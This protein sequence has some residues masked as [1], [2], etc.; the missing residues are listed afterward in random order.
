MEQVKYNGVI[1]DTELHA[2]WAVFFSALNIKWEYRMR[3]Y[4][5][6]ELGEYTPEFNIRL[7]GDDY[8]DADNLK[9]VVSVQGVPCE[10]QEKA[11]FF[12]EHSYSF[13]YGGCRFFREL[14]QISERSYV[15]NEE[16]QCEIPS[17][18]DSYIYAQMLNVSV[19]EYNRAIRTAQRKRLRVYKEKREGYVYRFIDRSGNVIYVGRTNDML[20]RM[21]QHFSSNG[22]L[23]KECYARTMRVEYIEVD[24]KNDMKIKELYYIG[25]LM[26]EYNRA[27]KVA[28][29][30][31]ID[32][33]VDKW[34]LYTVVKGSKIA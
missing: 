11:T 18:D 3:S 14:K 13:G 4:D 15:W 12:E 7:N 31:S 23:P 33:T 28:V 16:L 26:P 21:K 27:D 32:E 10:E 5:L 6:G 29:T 30:L 1:F 19:S 17:D 20:K 9:W 2:R 24:T 25:K 34:R 22:H 8:G